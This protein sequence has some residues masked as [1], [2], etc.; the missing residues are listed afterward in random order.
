MV[1]FSAK[2]GDNFH[3]YTLIQGCTNPRH[4]VTL[5][6]KFCTMAL[7]ICESSARNLHLSG[8][9]NSEVAPKFLENSWTPAFSTLHSTHSISCNTPWTVHTTVC[10]EIQNLISTLRILANKTRSILW[11][12]SQ[13]PVIVTCLLLCDTMQ[14][15]RHQ[16]LTGRNCLHLQGW[17]WLNSFI[18][19]K[20]IIYAIA[21]VGPTLFR[22]PPA[23]Y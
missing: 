23:R 8:T 18:S 10:T 4:Q 11:Q 16:Y 22:A 14:F 21:S 9:Y 2:W 12:I 1:F 15:H 6:T 13:W 19:Q 3:T 7:N 5:A 20:T 17:P